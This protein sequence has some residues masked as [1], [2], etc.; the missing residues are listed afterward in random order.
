MIYGNA[1][2]M[3]HPWETLIKVYREERGRES[4]ETVQEYAE[5]FINYL[6]QYQFGDHLDDANIADLAGATFQQVFNTFKREVFASRMLSPKDYKKILGKIVQ[7]RLDVVGQAA[8]LMSHTEADVIL[9]HGKTLSDNAKATFHGIADNNLAA[10]LS[11]LAVKEI[12]SSR[13]SSLHTGLVFA[14]FGTKQMFPSL[15][16]YYADGLVMGEMKVRRDTTSDT[17]INP[18]DE[19][20]VI[21]PFA[22]R[23]MAER[24][25]DGVDRRYQQWIDRTV[26]TLFKQNC[27][28]IVDKYV[29]VPSAQK[30]AIKAAVSRAV[31]K[32]LE[33][34]TKK[35]SEY[36]QR[37][38][39][40]PV[41][42]MVELLPKE[43]LAHLAES[44]VNLTS[45]RR[46]VTMDLESVGGPIDVAVIS[47]GDGFIWIKRKHYFQ[48][49]LNR[50]FIL[51]YLHSGHE[52]GSHE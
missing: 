22:V 19:A 50:S 12:I 36:R 9:K 47:K 32:N 29:N 20:A 31:T 5:H 2:I 21:I 44:L 14:G 49:D 51:N 25:M 24:F 7:E 38:F 40:N 42:N 35:E 43:E 4:C 8:S 27:L 18:L 26:R 46:R 3:Q 16:E 30:S 15:R 45:L 28:S 13:F 10:K 48:P 6:R 37:R 17:D 52:G 23:D 33:E 34:F 11:S 41:I 1:E 39:S